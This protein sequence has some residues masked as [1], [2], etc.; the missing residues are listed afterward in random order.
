MEDV[1]L[2]LHYVLFCFR[3]DSKVSDF[4]IFCP[5]TFSPCFCVT[6]HSFAIY[7]YIYMHMHS[8]LFQPNCFDFGDACIFDYFAQVPQLSLP[9]KNKF[10]LFFD[11]GICLDMCERCNAL[12]MFDFL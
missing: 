7:I 3:A 4:I 11:F 1:L 8:R 9:V 5:V 12:V 2:G 10:F 6:E